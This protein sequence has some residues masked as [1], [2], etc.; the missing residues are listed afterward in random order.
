MTIYRKDPDAVSNWFN[1]QL[2]GLG[3]RGSS[4]T[5]VDSVVIS[6]LTHDGSSRRF[7]FQEF[8]RPNEEISTGQW[9]ALADLARQPN[10][11]VWA[12][13]QCEGLSEVE[14]TS[15]WAVPK[16]GLLVAE[17]IPVDDYRQ[18]YADWWNQPCVTKCDDIPSRLVWA[19]Y[20]QHDPSLRAFIAAEIAR[21]GIQ[22]D[23]ATYNA[24]H[25]REVAEHLRHELD[26][27]TGKRQSRRS[28]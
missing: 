18:R 26:Q 7:L 11:T 23:T 25:Y 10:T 17:V 9:W 20:V 27:F 3:H 5:D 21:A 16:A 6:A 24:K 1:A 15:F 13:R 14:L 2:E 8:K 4:F 19:E 22:L 12:V 28:A